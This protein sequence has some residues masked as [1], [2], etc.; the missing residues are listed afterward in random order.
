MFSSSKENSFLFEVFQSIHYNCVKGDQF[1][2]GLIVKLRNFIEEECMVGLYYVEH[3]IALAHKHFQVV[4]KGNSSSLPMLNNKIQGLFGLRRVSSDGSC[5]PMQKVEGQGIAYLEEYGWAVHWKNSGEEHFEF[6]H[7]NVLVEVMND[8]TLEYAKVE[9]VGL[10][11]HVSLLR[12]N[13]LHQAHRWARFCIK[14]HLG[15]TLPDTPFHMC[16][17]GQ[18]YPNPTR[19]I[20]FFVVRKYGC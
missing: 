7:D 5:C 8:G 9:K 2:I 10:N 12:S 4:V 14:E 3:N 13:I 15:V 6:V 11:N 18:I 19:A 16:K 1:E 17:S 20:P